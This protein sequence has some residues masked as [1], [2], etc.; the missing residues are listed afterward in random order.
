MLLPSLTRLLIGALFILCTSPVFS[1]ISPIANLVH[2]QFEDDP[3]ITTIAPFTI[4]HQKNEQALKVAPNA[5]FLTLNHTILGEIC[6]NKPHNITLKLPYQGGT[7]LIDLTQKDITTDDFSII[8]ERSNTPAPY[9][10]GVHYRGIVRGDD[11][12][13]VGISFFEEEVMGGINTNN[14][15]KLVLGRLADRDNVD[16]YILYAADEMTVENPFSCGTEAVEA[17]PSIKHETHGGGAPE[18]TKCVRVFM[19]AD[20]ELFIDKGSSI[21]STVNYLLGMFNQTATLYANEQITTIASQIFVWTTP[22]IYTPTSSATVLNQFLTFRTSF[23]GDIAHLVGLGGNNLGG[24]AYV[25]VLCSSYKAAFSDIT[26]T[27]SNVPVYSWTVEVFTHEMGH[28][29]GSRH[30]QWCGWSGG[31]IDN[32]VSAEGSCSPGPT[33]TNGGT[34]M[35]YCHLTGIGI[36]FNNGFGPQPGGVIRNSVTNAS[37]VSASCPTASCDAPIALTI[38]NITGNGATIGWGTTNGATGY[39]LRYRQVGVGTWTTINTPTNPY[40]ITGLPANDEI[41]V[42][43]QSLCGSNSS[44]YRNG[45]LFI[46]GASGGSGGGGGTTCDAPTNLSAQPSSA[47]AQTSWNTANGAVSYSVQW[48]VNVSSTWGTAVSVTSNSYNINN[49]S[50]ATSYNVRVATV[51]NGATSAYSTTS[52]TTSGSG[53]GVTCNA[54]A[55]ISA[56]TTTTTAQSSWTAVNGASSYNLQWKNSTS[57]TWSTP[58]V[59]T[60]NSYAI[61]GLSAATNYDIRVSTACGSTTSGY[62]TG[63]FTTAPVAGCGASPTVTTVPAQTSAVVTWTSSAGANTYTLE[64]KLSTSSTWNNAVT[65]STTTYTINSLVANT[66]YDLR[67]TSTCANGVSTPTVSLFSTAGTTVNCNLP[68]NFNVT[69]GTNNAAT[70]WN[71]MTGASYYRIQWKAT[72]STAWSSLKTTFSANYNITSLLAGTAYQVRVATVCSTGQSVFTTSTFTTTGI[73]ASCGTPT[74]LSAVPSSLSA[75]TTWTGVT[76]ANSYS[77]QWK[78]TSSTVWGTAVSVTSAAYNIPNLSATTNYNVRVAAVCNGVLSSYITT[79]FLTTSSGS[80]GAPVT[81]TVTPTPV[82]GLVTWSLVAGAS[83]YQIQWK[84]TSSSAWSALTTIST[85]SFNITGLVSLTSYNVRVRSIC[86]GNSSA[87]TNGQFTTT[88]NGGGTACNPPATVSANNLQ[89][90]SIRIDWTTVNNAA[91]YAIRIRTVGNINWFTFTGLPSPGVTIQNLLP[92]TTYEVQV[93]VTCSNS[94]TSVYSPSTTFTTLAYLIDA[95]D[96][97]DFVKIPKNAGFTAFVAPNPFTQ[98]ARLVID[99]QEDMP[100]QITILNSFGQVI[101]DQHTTLRGGSADLDTPTL[102]NGVYFVRVR[103]ASE[104]QTVRVV[105]H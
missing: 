94:G 21:Q 93:A 28:N 40:T 13:V 65:L 36:N 19:E 95:E 100:A 4:L 30:T 45:T 80:C 51:C 74:N 32:C 14:K 67:L 73:G 53:G 31:P 5:Q 105:K 20:N 78:T 29:L 56:T 23:N 6:Q 99:N 3:E 47:S 8:T 33:P 11:R 104:V 76:G 39:V 58:V 96:R 101:S 90:T 42:T 61:S 98:N 54:P 82:S 57:A 77:I 55:N 10:S 63:T 60:T 87:Y 62:T 9:I 81:M 75:Q 64:W 7:L 88:N 83:A 49:L 26:T 35:S 12:S 44:D 91:S 27:Y 85:N 24:I 22:D 84:A 37:C 92:S 41:E 46:T 17:T 38:T 1:Q 59:V 89:V 102:P 69:A 103:I 50:A 34:I 86:N 97:F 71:S 2:T 48:K 52:F 25:D 15:G 16:H 72:N 68:A 18:V 70:S 79:S 66:A 43:I